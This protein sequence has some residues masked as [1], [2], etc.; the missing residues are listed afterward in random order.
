[1]PRFD[2]RDVGNLH[3][4]L[5]P[6][7]VVFTAPYVET[8]EGRSYGY[9]DELARIRQIWASAAAGAR[10]SRPSAPSFKTHRSL[11]RG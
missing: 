7:E 4:R 5:E 6:G 1:L 8:I 3:P 9:E 11:R 10:A 2:E